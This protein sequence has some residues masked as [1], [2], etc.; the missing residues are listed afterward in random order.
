MYIYIYI[1]I[2]MYSKFMYMYSYIHI[3]IYIYIFFVLFNN[4]SR[5]HQHSS[6]APIALLLSRCQL[7]P[8]THAKSASAVA[9][10]SCFRTRSQPPCAH[11]TCATPRCWLTPRMPHQRLSKNSLMPR[12]TRTCSVC[13][14]SRAKAGTS[15]MHCA[16]HRP[17]TSEPEQ[18]NALRPDWKTSQ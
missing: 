12:R 11:K 13:V 1:Y 17:S 4:F 6:S 10:S 7:A 5:Q 8:T 3:Y 16:P 15:A 9:G 14:R 2:Y 18:Y